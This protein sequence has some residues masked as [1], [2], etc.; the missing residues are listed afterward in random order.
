M[1]SLW[2]GL[3]QRSARRT[4]SSGVSANANAAEGP[5]GDGTTEK[6]G[7]QGEGEPA[8]DPQLEG[9]DAG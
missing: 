8:V 2:R 3:G 9:A 6:D 5:S 4:R 1:I 7:Q